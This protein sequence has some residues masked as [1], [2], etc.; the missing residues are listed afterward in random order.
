M[1]SVPASS[2]AT[3]DGAGRAG[4]RGTSAKAPAQRRRG[5]SVAMCVSLSSVKACAE[6]LRSFATSAIPGKDTEANPQPRARVE[7]TSVAPCFEKKRLSSAS[8]VS[9]GRPA[10]MI[11]S[12]KAWQSNLR[13][14]RGPRLL[15]GLGS[16]R[17]KQ[18]RMDREKR[19]VL[20]RTTICASRSPASPSPS[21][22][23]KPLPSA[24]WSTQK[25]TSSPAERRA[26][27][28]ASR[29]TAASLSPKACCSSSLTIV[30]MSSASKAGPCPSS[31]GGCSTTPR[32]FRKRC[33][34]TACG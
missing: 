25:V 2:P 17:V 23:A 7:T 20:A 21:S 26:W 33:T 13:S 15:R 32:Y 30:P 5:C 1:T 18:P 9:P 24:P 29:R 14:L 3:R 27:P 6:R 11:R 31:S 34:R 19:L 16:R 10:R 8:S 22:P 4:R 12:L 28:H